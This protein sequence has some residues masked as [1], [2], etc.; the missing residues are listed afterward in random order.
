VIS[1]DEGADTIFG[2][3]GNDTISGG[4][5]SDT[6]SGGAGTDQVDGGSGNDTVSGNDGR[7]FLTG[8]AG[9]DTLIGGRGD[10]YLSGGYGPGHYTAGSDTY[11][12]SSGDGNDTIDD[13]AYFSADGDSVDTLKF[14]D[15]NLADVTLSRG[16][17]DHLYVR[18]N[19]T[20]HEIKVINH[21]GI[22]IS[23]SVGVGI[24]RI[25]FADSSTLD[26]TQ[27][28]QA[29]WYQGTAF[30]DEIVGDYDT[31]S[32]TFY[33][34]GGDD[35]I[36]S[37]YT[38]NSGS[39][40]YVYYAGD[41]NDVVRDSTTPAGAIDTLRL[42]NIA[43]QDVVLERRGEHLIVQIVPTG[44]RITIDGQFG[45]RQAINLT[46]GIEQIEF[47]DGVTFDRQ[48]ISAEAWYRGTV[49]S[50]VIAVN[51]DNATIFG[52]KGDDR[53]QDASATNAGSTTYVYRTGDGSDA[54]YDLAS[55]SYEGTDRLLLTD[56][57]SEDIDLRFNATN[58]SRL[59]QGSDLFI[60]IMETGE[61]I[62]VFSQFDSNRATPDGSGEGLEAIRFANGEEW[63]AS[64][65]RFLAHEGARFFT[66]SFDDNTII[67]SHLDQRLNG[68]WGH[69]VIDGKTGSDQLYGDAG[70]DRLVISESLAGDFDALDGGDGVDT[71]DVSGFAA[72]VLIDFVESN[73]V[74]RTSGSAQFNPAAALDLAALNRIESAIGSAFADQIFGDGNA[75]T[76]SGGSGDDLLSG[77]S[78]NDTLRGGDGDDTLI[79]GLGNDALYGGMGSDVYAIGV[80]DANDTLED[81]G[82][83][84]D[85]DRLEIGANQSSVLAVRWKDDLRIEHSNGSV[86]VKGQFAPGASNGIELIEFDNA[87]ITDI[88]GLASMSF[89]QNVWMSGS[90]GDDVVTGTLQSD[91]L[92]GKAGNDQLR[93]GAGADLY[94]Y[95]GGYG[96]DVVHDD[97]NSASEIDSL[98]LWDLDLEMLKF[99]R[100]GQNLRIT[101]NATG[102]TLTVTDQF[103]SSSRGV[104]RIQFANNLVLDRAAIALAAMPIVEGT[105]ASESLLGS[106]DHDRMY[107]FGGND[108]VSGL[109]GND[110]LVGGLGNDVLIGG[111]GND[112]YVYARGDGNDEIDESGNYAG[113]SD[114]LTLVDIASGS[115]SLQRTG[116]TATLVIAESSVGAG[117]GGRITLRSGLDMP[118]ERGVESVV[119]SDGVTWTAN[120]M[121]TMILAAASTAGDDVIVGFDSADLLSGGDGNDVLDGS[122]GNDILRGG[123]GADV[124]T[125]GGGAD[126]LDGGIG[127]DTASFAS[128]STSVVANLLAGTAT[129][130]GATDTLVS[131]ENVIG[132]SGNDVLS[133]DA[134]ANL[135]DGQA[136]NDNLFGGDGDDVLVGGAGTDAFDG[137]S[138]SDTA[139]FAHSTATWTLDLTTG[140]ATSGSSIEVL[141]SI[142]N[143][144][145]GS[146]NDTLRGDNVAN[147]L[148]GDAGNDILIGGL[149]ADTF[150]FGNHFG[151]DT[152]T[153]FSILDGD[154]IDL[155]KLGLADFASL[156][157][158]L[159][160][161][162]GSTVLNVAGHGTLT[163]QGIELASL[164]ETDFRV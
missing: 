104:E 142:E 8:G 75:N 143:L 115:V 7:D 86:L 100:T 138:G 23:T 53:L 2:D 158:L 161:A 47:S 137:G 102:E 119:F 108:N 22:D 120:D 87:V 6:L 131:I 3:G 19:A 17:D 33:G 113:S 157:S 31:P 93:G 125:G 152:V 51:Y 44:E 90:S 163:L 65:I 162:S 54:I 43:S 140:R 146:A 76:L 151:G 49:F 117:D 82:D 144:I 159:S 29:A 149:G 153:D 139:S 164:S 57:N 126:N 61:E 136:G 89:E 154:I 68:D 88:S 4:T 32:N 42:M 20:G 35:V 30:R 56:I 78:G 105:A 133:G 110:V 45:Y 13:L 11:V 130:G 37:G 69:D 74:V 34:A 114:K 41:G 73:G 71:V 98:L 111:T 40:V 95:G 1:G 60:R 112:S 15:L 97:S 27:I 16:N 150:V 156:Q 77:R 84:S 39:D 18:V 5:G 155:S 83:A 85:V 160:E 14:T 141:T 103:L 70:D 79:G 48:K 135:L 148:D 107:A 50:D 52:G 26:R 63:T 132:G 145:G 96:A 55:A 66:G 38:F 129:T 24:D 91:V 9:D 28:R 109:Q 123:A 64:M 81:V 25:E 101:I 58:D 118:Y 46:P 94:I 12:Y 128:I 121:R 92:I 72:A 116:L 124:L 106:A 67:G 127:T 36:V 80:N 59:N 134:G 122:N 10:D 99:E 147:V 21:F 62:R